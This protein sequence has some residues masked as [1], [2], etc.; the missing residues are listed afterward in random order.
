MRKLGAELLFALTIAAASYAQETR[1]G[2]L[3]RVKDWNGNVS[4]ADG[5]LQVKGHN[6]LVSHA[7]VKVDPTKLYVLSGQFRAAA[8]STSTRIYFG[9]DLL[10]KDRKPFGWR[11]I[12]LVAGTLTELVGDVKAGDTVIKV[13]DASKCKSDIGH[14]IAFDVDPY[15]TCRDLPNRNT[16][17]GI[18][19]IEKKNGCYELTVSSP[20]RTPYPAGT[21][22]REHVD[23][24]YLYAGGWGDVPD[25]W[26]SFS[27]TASGRL[28]PGQ[29][30]SHDKWWPKAEYARILILANWNKNAETVQFR[31]I[32]LEVR[33]K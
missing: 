1:T 16:S 8:G 2:R 15:P 5:A 14:H 18:A 21:Y 23:G 22:V 29:T 10:D 9:F 4:S 7:T 28:R 32:A 31:D 11:E 12:G 25:T 27:G 20:M 24:P 33:A 19:K 30:L 13:K 6:H 17:P 26:R 3:S